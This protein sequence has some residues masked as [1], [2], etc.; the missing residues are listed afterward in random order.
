MVVCQVVR[1]RDSAEEKR[2]HEIN[3]LVTDIAHY[4]VILG[5]ARL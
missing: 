2:S 4:D 3:F 5:T 1:L